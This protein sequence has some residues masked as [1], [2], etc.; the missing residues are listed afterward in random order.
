MPYFRYFR[1][2][3]SM[4][5]VFARMF[6]CVRTTPLGSAVAPD[7]KM[8]SAVSDADT[9]TAGIAASACQSMP[10]RRHTAAPSRL[11][12]ACSPAPASA[13][14]SSP[15]RMTRA[16]TMARMRRTKSRELR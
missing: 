7:V 8:I 2:S 3:C 9:R 16:S 10:A 4:G 11:P 5:I 6:R 15:A 14:R 12:A 1:T 13:G